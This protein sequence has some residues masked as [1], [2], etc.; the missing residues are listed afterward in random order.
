MMP[1]QSLIGV[2]ELRKLVFS[3]LETTQKPA[4]H[5][6][7]ARALSMRRFIGQISLP[8]SLYERADDEIK[9]AVSSKRRSWDIDAD[10][11]KVRCGADSSMFT[12]KILCGRP[13]ITPLAWVW[14]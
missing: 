6:E 8:I 10:D 7:P 1:N 13:E 3:V 9:A 11:G 2:S 4:S 12:T 14:G 5:Q